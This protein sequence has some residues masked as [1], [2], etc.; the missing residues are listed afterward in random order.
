M[1]RRP[2]T[3]NDQTNK[4]AEVGY[5]HPP[6]S[7][8]FRKGQSGNPRGRRKGQRN[9]APVLTEVLSQFVTV[10]QGGKSR[11][12][13]KGDALILRLMSK[14]QN[15]DASAVK[16]VLYCLEKVARIDSP[17]PQLG[18]HGGYEFLLVP[19]MAASTEEWQREIAARHETAEIREIITAGRAKGNSLTTSQRAALRGMVDAARAVGASVTPSQMRALRLSLGLECP[20]EPL[21]T[22]TR[23][24]VNRIDRGFVKTNTA[25]PSSSETATAAQTAADE[26][27]PPSLSNIPRFPRSPTGTYRQ[28]NRRKPVS[29]TTPPSDISTSQPK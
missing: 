2:T 7:S 19:G 12:V 24:P 22:V 20:V 14:A 5:Q 16:A 27:A 18:G 29:P 4:D 23:R 11:R 21:P 10:K 13:S 17:E 9:L 8:Q 28:V 25:K 3:S 1:R 26:T 15:G 6:A